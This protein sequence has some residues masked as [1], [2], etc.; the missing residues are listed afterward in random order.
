MLKQLQH[1]YEKHYKK[2]MLIPLVL[3]LF[4]TGVLVF[5]QANTGDFIGKDV[6]LQ[7]G[8]VITVSS[9]KAIDVS[10]VEA[11]LGATL[12]TSVRITELSSIGAGG[13]IGY[14]FEMATGVDKDAAI[15][16]IGVL[17]GGLSTENYTVEE[18]SASLG[19][20]FWS[21]TIKAVLI[22]FVF[23]A[24]V[25]VLYF[26]K[27]PSGK[28]ILFSIIVALATAVLLFDNIASTATTIFKFLFKNTITYA[29]AITLGTVFGYTIA[30]MLCILFLVACFRYSLP[31]LAIIYAA[32][33]DFIGVLAIM[34]LIGM[35]LSSAGV[36]ALLMLI[37]Y[38]VDSD[39]LL[40]TKVIKRRSGTVLHRVYS[41]MKTGLTMEVTTLAALI[42]LYVVAPA[43]T[44]KTISTVLIIGITLDLPSTWLMNAG[45][46]RWW[47]ERKNK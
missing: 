31:S 27:S 4:F 33:A 12:D 44:L 17:Y 20:S 2:L 28:A 16:Q 38:S 23:M 1:I 40:A 13:R 42:V 10:D 8:I 46:L 34:N 19:A 37:G 15:E 14:S 35:R 24:F 7:G 43:S 21:S 11:S 26:G 18:I 5:Q 30:I 3:L 47:M 36:A 39:V 29:T 9:D 45:I 22:A 32:V 6:S 25:I 41:A